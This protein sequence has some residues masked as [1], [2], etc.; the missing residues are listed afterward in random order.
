MKVWPIRAALVIQTILCLA[1]LFLYLTWRHFGWSLSPIGLNTLRIALALLSFS[2]IGACI[3]AFRVVHPFVALAYKLAVLW[4]GFLHLFF[5]AAVT[6]WVIDPVT[7]LLSKPDRLA[8]RAHLAAVLLLTV[9]ILALYSL[10][11][12]R[13]IR[14]RRISVRLPNLPEAWRGRTALLL[15]DLHLGNVNSQGFASRIARMART[16]NPHVILISGDLFDGLADKP[17]DLAAPLIDLANSIGTYFVSGNH[18][19]FGGTSRY[20][21]AFEPTPIHVLDNRSVNLDGLHIIGV[22]YELSTSPIS[23][24]TYLQD[25]NLAPDQPS[26]LLNHVPHGLPIVAENNV[27]LQLSGHTHGGQM[28]P[29]NYL[30]RRAFGRFTYG[31]QQ[32]DSLKVYT[33]SGAGTWGP[34]MRLGSAPEIVLFTFEP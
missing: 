13:I 4:L 10:A 17:L 18:E 19:Q 12:A 32:L 3:F 20:N 22:S 33:S 16:L 7:L 30:A 25:L 5:L 29:F 27:S 34:P 31:L 21:D 24:R 8:I 9:L 1:H 2:F 11:N 26:I 15:T 6:A 28:F 14:T 23:F